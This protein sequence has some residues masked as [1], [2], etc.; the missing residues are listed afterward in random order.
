MLWLET[1][2]IVV[3]TAFV[4]C[5]S[6]LLIISIVRRMQI[7]H[8]VRSGRCFVRSRT[9]VTLLIV[10]IPGVFVAMSVPVRESIDIGLVT[11]YVLG[12]LSWLISAYINESILITRYGLVFP[13]RN[14]RGRIGWRQISDFFVVRHMGMT[15][16]VLIW[17][18]ES[19]AL[20]RHELA[21]PRRLVKSIELAV[22]TNG[23]MKQR[24]PI[25]E[26]LRP[27]P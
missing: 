9:L 25:S 23:T 12:S 16:V 26:Q 10:A 17:K 2:R 5:T 19:G 1:S 27:V 6:L 24:R 7:R 4:C 21:V 15:Q 18:E 13:S 14:I 20:Y 3:L 8:V 22:E 11:G